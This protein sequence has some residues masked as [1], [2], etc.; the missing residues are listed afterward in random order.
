MT[1]ELYINFMF[2]QVGHITYVQFFMRYHEIGCVVR[3]QKE[4]SRAGHV[5]LLPTHRAVQD[6]LGTATKCVVRI[7]C[8]RSLYI[9]AKAMVLLA[10]PVAPSVRVLDKASRV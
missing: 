3:R 9:S 2:L 5:T 7:L 10:R 4:N 1:S 8:L 6:G